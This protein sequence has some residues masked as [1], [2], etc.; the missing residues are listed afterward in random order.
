MPLTR[1]RPA[2]AAALLGATLAT[3]AAEPAFDRSPQPM[4]ANPSPLPPHWQQGVFMEIFVRA[5]QDSDG[6]GVGDLRGLVSRL[7]D[8]K[9][10]GIRGIWLMPITASADRDHGYATTDHRAVEPDYG[11][12]EDVDTLLR[13][14]HARGIGVVMDYV[15]NHASHRHPAFQAALADERSPWRR[16]FMWSDT[17]PQG[18]DIWGKNPWYWAGAQPWDFQGEYKDLPKPP[19]GA[20]GH[21]FGTFGPHMPDF[22]FRHPPVLEYHLDSLRFWL[23]RGLDGFRL[24]AVPH[25]VE[26][27]A[28]HW[29]DQPESRALTQ[30]LQDTTLAYP[31]R[32]VVCEATA[33]PQ[34]YGDPAVCGGAFAFGYQHHYIGAAKGQAESVAELARYYRHA[35]PTM[36]TFLSSHD[37]FAGLRL[38]DQVGGDEA[39]Y[40]LA[41]AGYLLQPG[42]P[43]VYYG[44]EVGQ[45]SLPGLSGDG[46]IR[47]SMSWS[48]EPRG[49]GF[50]P[51]GPWLGVSPNAATHN[52]DAQKRDP[53]SIRSFYQ[54]VIGWRNQRPSL[55]RGDFAHSFA[56]GLLLGFQRRLG[57]ERT[58]VLINYGHG[59]AQPTPE[60]LALP[61]G[62]SPRLLWRS[63][64]APAGASLF[65][66]APQ[67]VALVALDD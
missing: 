20:R 53:G 13:E 21:Y 38:W 32:Y 10:L 50:S 23:N 64:P 67:S 26:N 58:L 59:T 2:L 19:P 51:K 56:D 40:K 17:P 66:M 54:T 41:A 63:A 3:G 57:P 34:A 48:A 28:A 24:D 29:N 46:P 47:G 4:R 49:A 65:T 22:D 30:R 55:A 45:A 43:F 8:L 6:D 27:D 16:W 60:A 11:T 36:A 42:T 14:A 15:I 39:R 5:Y 33:E 62:R 25:M 61:A 52:A 31:N 37:I 9:D 12:L 35:R 1:S 7:D 18:W 44:E